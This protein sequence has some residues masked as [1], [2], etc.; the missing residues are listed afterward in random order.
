MI[1]TETNAMNKESIE[2]DLNLR[3]IVCRETEKKSSESM[4]LQGSS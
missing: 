2:W 4:P 3:S 1:Y